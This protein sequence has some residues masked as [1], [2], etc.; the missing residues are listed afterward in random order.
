ML[1]AMHFANRILFNIFLIRTFID[2]FVYSDG[3][4]FFEAGDVI[5]WLMLLLMF[6][7][8]LLVIIDLFVVFVVNLM[9]FFLV[10]PFIVITYSWSTLFFI[11]WK[12][13]NVIIEN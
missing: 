2:A 9:L 1:D 6:F 5:L 13:R 12:R 10:F 7:L 3:N 8:S 4:Q 11:I